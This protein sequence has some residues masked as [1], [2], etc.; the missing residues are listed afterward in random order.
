V[1]GGPCLAHEGS[2]TRKPIFCDDEGKPLPRSDDLP[3]AT[4][5]FFVCGVTK[6]AP[7]IENMA[8]MA[9]KCF[10]KED[11]ISMFFS[12][13]PLAASQAGTPQRLVSL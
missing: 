13:S 12:W 8:P 3:R 5:I 9:A 4:D 1:L 10:L 2:L 11:P 6:G 7:L